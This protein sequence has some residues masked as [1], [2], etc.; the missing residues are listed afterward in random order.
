[1]QCTQN[2][3][4]FKNKFAKCIDKSKQDDIMT[5]RREKK[6]EKTENNKLGGQTTRN[7][8]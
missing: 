3:R 1:M 7:V 8:N 4:K 5:V 6:K 2:V